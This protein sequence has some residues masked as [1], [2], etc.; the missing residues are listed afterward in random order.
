MGDEQPPSLEELGDDPDEI[1]EYWSERTTITVRRYTK[2]RLDAHREGRP[3]DEYL[4]LLR[5]EHADP[6]T[7]NDVESIADALKEQI[8]PMLESAQEDWEYLNDEEKHG[9]I[10]ESEHQLQDVINR[11]DDLESRLPRKVKEELR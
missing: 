8:Q 1:G 2:E 3:W 11:I 10:H 4:E 5:R 9:T 7:F 6:I